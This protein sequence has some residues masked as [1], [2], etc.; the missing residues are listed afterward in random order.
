MAVGR[1]MTKRSNQDPLRIE[2][3]SQNTQ[4]GVGS[5]TAERGYGGGGVIRLNLTHNL[6]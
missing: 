5:L 3:Q 4:K 2:S 1:Y 6:L